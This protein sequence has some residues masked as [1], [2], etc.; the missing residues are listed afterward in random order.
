MVVEVDEA[1][2]A[3]IG[4]PEGF[5]LVPVNALRFEDGEKVFSHSVVVTVTAP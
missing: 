2:N 4:F 1:V 3:F 5:R